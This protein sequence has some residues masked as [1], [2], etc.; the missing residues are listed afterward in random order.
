[1]GDKSPDI[2]GDQAKHYHCSG[3][4]EQAKDAVQEKGTVSGHIAGM[5]PELALAGNSVGIRNCGFFTSFLFNGIQARKS[6]QM[7]CFQY[8]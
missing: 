8:F 6:S 3:I 4:F 2:P 5:K 1:M 7:T